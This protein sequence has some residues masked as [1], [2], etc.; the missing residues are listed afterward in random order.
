[1]AAAWR[2]SGEGGGRAGA[3]A[4]EDSWCRKGF[5]ALRQL[6]LP[7]GLLGSSL[8]VG[9]PLPA[10]RS[11]SL[12]RAARRTGTSPCAPLSPRHLLSSARS[13]GRPVQGG[14]V[15]CL[16][17]SL[18]P[19][20]QRRRPTPL[21]PALPPF[22][23][24]WPRS[25][26]SGPRGCT[27]TL[28]PC[29]ADQ[30]VRGRGCSFRATPGAPARRPSLGANREETGAGTGVGGGGTHGWEGREPGLMVSWA[31]RVRQPQRAP[32]AWTAAGAGPAAASGPHSSLLP[33]WFTK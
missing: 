1:M 3:L 30:S 7:L 33:L 16:H 13:H 25:I 21:Q 24:K 2:G 28:R 27:Q 12:E 9:L 5:G 10:V 15:S 6:Q 32:A 4:A 8:R 29:F 14:D 31:L 23:H 18:R 19:W 22:H 26:H 17:L 11:L 20:E